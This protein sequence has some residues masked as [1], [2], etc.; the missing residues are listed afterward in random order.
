MQQACASE[1][2]RSRKI[3]R[4]KKTSHP[5]HHEIHSS[6]ATAANSKPHAGKHVSRVSPYFPASIV[7]E[8]VEIG[9]VQLWQSITKTNVKHTH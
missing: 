2:E 1:E 5:K 3:K 9:L 7:P 8:F 6:P 4:G